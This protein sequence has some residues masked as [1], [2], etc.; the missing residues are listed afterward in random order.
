MA[1]HRFKSM[2]NRQ[3]SSGN[4]MFGLIDHALSLKITIEAPRESERL[5]KYMRS[6]ILC[7]YQSEKKKAWW[8]EVILDGRFRVIDFCRKYSKSRQTN[9]HFGSKLPC[10]VYWADW[11]R[12]RERTR[13]WYSRRW[14]QM[15]YWLVCKVMIRQ[16]ESSKLWALFY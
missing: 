2:L 6:F 11:E 12:E 4:M 5:E 3:M 8:F 15:L 10:L 14:C 1:Y 16:T 9:Q 7:Q 13:S